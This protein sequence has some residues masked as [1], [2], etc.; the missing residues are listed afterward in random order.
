[1]ICMTLHKHNSMVMRNTNESKERMF[2]HIPYK[3]VNE[4]RKEKS[5]DALNGSE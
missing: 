5:I 2:N 3:E 4:E 1:M